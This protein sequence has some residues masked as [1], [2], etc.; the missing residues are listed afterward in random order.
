M[1]NFCHKT[2]KKKPNPTNEAIE[3]NVNSKPL[4]NNEPL[5]FVLPVPQV[6]LEISENPASF[7]SVDGKASSLNWNSNLFNLKHLKEPD[8]KDSLRILAETLKKGHSFLKKRSS[9]QASH[10][11]YNKKESLDLYSKGNYPG[12]FNQSLSF[13]KE[14]E[15]SGKSALKIVSLLSENQ[16]ISHFKPAK[17]EKKQSNSMQ[18]Q[19]MLDF[20]LTEPDDVRAFSL[21]AQRSNINHH[22]F[23]IWDAKIHENPGFYHVNSSFTDFSFDRSKS[24]ELELQGFI[25]KRIRDF[26][27]GDVGRDGFFD[28]KYVRQGNC[29]SCSLVAALI[30]IAY[31]YRGLLES[32]LFPKIDGKNFTNTNGKYGV[33]INCNGAMR[34]IEIDDYL[35]FHKTQ[36]IYFGSFSLETKDFWSS[37]FEKA[38][39]KYYGDSY[40]KIE[41]NSA[42]ETFHLI[43][44]IPQIIT[45]NTIPNKDNLWGR[46]YQNYQEKNLLINLGT[47][48]ELNSSEKA[49]FPL[50]NQHTYS[51]LAMQ[52]TKSQRRLLLRNPWGKSSS[53]LKM[54]N[55][56][57]QDLLSQE[58]LALGLFYI[59]WNAAINAFSSIYLSWNPEIYPFQKGFLSKWLKGPINNP[60]LWNECYSVEFNPQFLLRIPPH[61]EEFELRVFLERHISNTTAHKGY[62]NTAGFLLFPYQG[63]RTI[64]PKDPLKKTA[65]S[66]NE[67]ITDVFIFEKS[68]QEDLYVL[69]VLKGN[70]QGNEFLTVE[71]ETYFSIKFLSFLNI[72]IVEMPFRGIETQKCFDLLYESKELKNGGSLNSPYFHKNPHYSLTINK[73]IDLRIQI[74][75]PD[76]CEV[77]PILIEQ[78]K[79]VI[80]DIREIPLK[81]IVEGISQGFF[82]EGVGSLEI[83][84]IPGKYTL[85]LTVKNCVDGNY[86]IIFSELSEEIKEFPILS[87]I[88]LKESNNFFVQY[89]ENKPQKFEKTLVGEWNIA[90][91]KGIGRVNCNKYQNF[92]RNPGYIL[93]F[94]SPSVATFS[95]KSLD[96]EILYMNHLIENDKNDDEF[97]YEPPSIGLCLYEIESNLNFKLIF[98]DLLSIPA[99]WGSFIC[100]FPIKNSENPYLLLCLNYEKGYEGSYQLEIGST[101]AFEIKENSNLL[102][103]KGKKTL[104]GKWNEQNYGGCSSEISFYKNPIYELSFNNILN[105]NDKKKTKESQNI[106][107]HIA[108]ECSNQS[109]PLGLYLFECHNE[110]KYIEDM[111]MINIIETTDV[112]LKEVNTISVNV[113]YD[114][115]YII[116]A[117]THKS[118][119][120]GE[121]LL[122]VYSNLENEKIALREIPKKKEILNSE[123]KTYMGQWNKKSVSKS[124]LIKPKKMSGEA[125]VKIHL[126]NSQNKKCG[127][128]FYENEKL[129]LQ[130]LNNETLS[131]GCFAKICVNNFNSTYK[132]EMKYLED[133]FDGNV[134]FLYEIEF[135]KKNEIDIE[136]L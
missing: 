92:M 91:S 66:A 99:P 120:K 23:P 100:D 72:Q 38:I 110:E 103:L 34:F 32:L 127:I 7:S 88:S 134:N 22:H 31:H 126:F 69:V 52:E 53:L 82:S 46:L 44:Y 87:M 97:D 70:F 75:G 67:L 55:E 47:N 28:W 105:D 43:G 48:D 74:E 10:G 108:I 94:S 115:K 114:K 81:N 121:F 85:I 45:I 78:N 119:Q 116:L 65:Y 79:N 36:H 27:G 109:Y 12:K 117:C 24:Q 35:P 63:E 50:E 136:I 57:S 49:N 131:I 14:K 111:T 18:I 93:K 71:N 20:S 21:L 73:T 130:K 62:K 56:D 104:K 80:K 118:G 107:C 19:K 11:I 54:S 83:S 95:L 135:E 101:S 112:F 76:F 4:N 51:V 8:S 98:E 77:M 5:P 3:N 26:E 128:F 61:N 102:E 122:T 113:Q 89:M 68:L 29:Q 58:D 25:W 2:L 40:Y 64:F 132:V 90:N 96:Y 59:D 86:K 106:Q 41:S 123:K 37:L 33:K 42:I 6:P 84:L 39:I 129:A 60:K 133:D 30:T 16:S 124:F 13:F 15:K 125:Y 9:R 1:G 17:A